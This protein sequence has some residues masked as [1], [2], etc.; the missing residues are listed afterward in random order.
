MTRGNGA[1][2][3]GVIEMRSSRGSD[4]WLSGAT[5]PAGVKTLTELSAPAKAT[6]RD[7]LD[8]AVCSP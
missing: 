5:V 8:I 4:R 3:D 7:V 6:V 2:T 1:V